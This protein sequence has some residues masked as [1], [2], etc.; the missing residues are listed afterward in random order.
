MQPGGQRPVSEEVILAHA[1]QGFHFV[2]FARVRR[3]K[4]TL[5]GTQQAVSAPALDSLPL[6][7]VLLY[8]ASSGGI[9]ATPTPAQLPKLAAVEYAAAAG[10]GANAYVPQQQAS[11]SPQGSGE[12]LEPE[13][14]VDVKPSP[15]PAP[16]PAAGDTSNLAETPLLDAGSV[17]GR[18]RLLTGRKLR[19]VQMPDG[20]TE[21]SAEPTDLPLSAVGQLLAHGQE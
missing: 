10:T 5:R 21:V 14:T 3:V 4:A 9:Y 19:A 8:D 13:I 16:S 20:R 18:R 11:P 7:R 6:D 2:D 17:G 12:I 1:A 15:S